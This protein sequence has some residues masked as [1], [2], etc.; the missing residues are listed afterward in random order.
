MV[1]ALLHW[2][3]LLRIE[4]TPL[5]GFYLFRNTVFTMQPWKEGFC[6]G[7]DIFVGSIAVN[8]VKICANFDFLLKN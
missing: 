3:M 6:A 5:E 8:L 4:L 2:F 7:S 1:L